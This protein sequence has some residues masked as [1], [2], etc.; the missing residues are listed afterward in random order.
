MKKIK[1]GARRSGTRYGWDDIAERLHALYLDVVAA[2]QQT[3]APA[4]VPVAM[5]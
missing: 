1:A 3:H 2:H 4:P 5:P